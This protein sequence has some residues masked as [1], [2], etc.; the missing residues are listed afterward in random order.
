MSCFLVHVKR[1]A[2]PCLRQTC[3]ASCLAWGATAPVHA[4][5]FQ[6]S[7]GQVD[8]QFDTDA[9]AFHREAYPGYLADISPSSLSYTQV[10][11]GVEINFNDL[12]SLYATSYS[13]FTPQTLSGDF[14][15]SFGIT[16]RAGYVITGYTVTYSGTY[17]IET[18]GSVYVGSTTAGP[19]TAITGSGP[20]NFREDVVGAVSPA[21]T[22]SFS[23][24]G[25][26]NTIQ[27]FDGY[28]QVFDHNETVLDYCD[29]VEP[30]T[31]YYHEEP[32]YIGQPIY[33]DETDLGEAQL[34]LQKITLLVHVTAVP[35]SGAMAMVAGV[36]PMLAWWARRRRAEMPVAWRPSLA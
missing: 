12:L 23:A 13:Y 2:L 27:V 4:E 30:F 10:G 32:V 8:I 14:S 11:Q 15:A 26:L 28:Q 16:P 18:P 21:L 20:F 9:F 5:A 25:D 34:S 6:W 31:C 24:T 3:L 1:A 17:S 36:L 19:F 35:E 7:T 29:A 33:H 22:G